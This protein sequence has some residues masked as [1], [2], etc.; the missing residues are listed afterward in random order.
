MTDV[1]FPAP[2]RAKPAPRGTIHAARR[3]WATPRGVAWATPSAAGQ[4]LDVA[5][6]G[7]SVTMDG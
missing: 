3:G 2:A 1:T 5:A 6:L 4:C 7:S